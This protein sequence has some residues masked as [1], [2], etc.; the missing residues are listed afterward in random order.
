MND[1][2]VIVVEK[3]KSFYPP[4]ASFD[5]NFPTSSPPQTIAVMNSFRS[6]SPL[7]NEAALAAMMEQVSPSRPLSDNDDEDEVIAV[8][9]TARQQSPPP[10]QRG[11][12]LESE[13]EDEMDIA[14]TIHGISG[15]PI[16]KNMLL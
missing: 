2:Q 10:L 6:P 16:I 4:P 13:S 9:T 12:I 14:T 11:L 3:R 1:L 7:L 15:S 5:L 8:T